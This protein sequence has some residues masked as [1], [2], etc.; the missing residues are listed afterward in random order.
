MIRLVGDAGVDVGLSTGNLIDKSL[1]LLVEGAHFLELAKRNILNINE[2][3]ERRPDVKYFTYTLNVFL[4]DN[5]KEVSR[6]STFLSDK[7][8]SGTFSPLIYE[9]YELQSGP[10]NRF[11]RLREGNN[12][13][14]VVIRLKIVTNIDTALIKGGLV[15]MG[16]VTAQLL[17]DIGAK[18]IVLVTRSGKAKNYDSQHLE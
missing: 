8:E 14:N 7:L 4:L 15:G 2:M 11:K 13:G 9:V 6:I 3:E 18:H 16:L 12:I 1:D 17:C 5:P 10:I